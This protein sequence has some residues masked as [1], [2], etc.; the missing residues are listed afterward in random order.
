MSW[1]PSL[2]RGLGRSRCDPRALR[3]AWSWYD[4]RRSARTVQ[5]V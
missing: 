5:R 1:L 3:H 4:P 2:L